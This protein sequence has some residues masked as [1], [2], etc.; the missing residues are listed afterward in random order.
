MN[1]LITGFKALGTVIGAQI[2][3]GVA[4]AIEGLQA[5]L[6]ASVLSAVGLGGVDAAGLRQRANAA[7]VGATTEFAEITKASAKILADDAARFKTI[8]DTTEAAVRAFNAGGTPEAILAASQGK[9]P[10]TADTRPGFQAKLRYT[11]LVTTIEFD[12]ETIRSVSRRDGVIV[13]N[14]ASNEALAGSVDALTGTVGLLLENPTL[15]RV[16]VVAGKDTSIESVVPTGG[17][18]L[19]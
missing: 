17:A 16:E 8:L 3:S 12:G 19:P 9:A 13:D 1:L 18:N 5:I 6:P 2:T 4:T 14:T 11:P 15:A 10:G 7:S